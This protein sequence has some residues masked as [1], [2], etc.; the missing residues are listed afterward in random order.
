MWLLIILLA[1]LPAPKPAVFLVDDTRNHP[2]FNAEAIGR[3]NRQ[4]ACWG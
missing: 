1:R 3:G 4:T 2:A